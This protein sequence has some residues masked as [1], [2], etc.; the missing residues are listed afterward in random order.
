MW[1]GISVMAGP[2]GR[3]SKCREVILA[4]RS[5]VRSSAKTLLL[6]VG[7][8]FAALLPRR[9]LN[10]VRKIRRFDAFGTGW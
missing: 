1:D 2:S 4:D 5:V 10:S 6:L 3:F 8:L 7:D 9:T